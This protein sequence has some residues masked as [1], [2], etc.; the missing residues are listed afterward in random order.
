MLAPY[1]WAEWLLLGSVVAHVVIAPYTKVEESFNLQACHDLLYH[2]TE[3]TAYDHH[4]FPGVV[5]RT[6]LGAVRV[7]KKAAVCIVPCVPCVPCVSCVPCVPCV[8]CAVR[9]VPC[10]GM[11]AARWVRVWG[12]SLPARSSSAAC[13]CQK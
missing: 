10:A 13:W 3:L 9:R 1:W 8:P 12:R 6:F 11:G 4:M 2:N 5:P 7:G